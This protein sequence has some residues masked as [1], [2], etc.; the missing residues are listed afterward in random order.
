MTSRIWFLLYNLICLPLMLA[1]TKLLATC[2][3]KIRESIKK[4]EGLWVRLEEGISKRGWQ[5]P[6]LW[7]HVA[8]AGEFLQAQPVIARC[9]AEG[10]E[11]VLT[12]SSINAFR[13]LQSPGQTETYN[14]LVTD[15]LPVE[16]K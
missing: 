5:K 4:R 1:T 3:P 14:L 7:F 12:F 2:I 16:E 6:L 11:C 8:S 15:F 10:T 9:T 13:W